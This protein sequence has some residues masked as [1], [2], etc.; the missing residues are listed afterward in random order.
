MFRNCHKFYLNTDIVITDSLYTK[1]MSATIASQ[2]LT[3]EGNL[4]SLGTS[5][6]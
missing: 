3:T 2:I 1:P 6:V 5:Y 4:L